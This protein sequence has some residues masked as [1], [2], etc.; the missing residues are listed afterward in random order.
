MHTE[1]CSPAMRR[2][3]ILL[4]LLAGFTAAS[5]AAPAEFPA[6]TG[7][8]VDEAGLLS[9]AARAQL[10]GELAAHEQ[11]TTNQVVVVTLKSLQGY[12]IDDYGYQLGR[13]WGIGQAKLNN[14]VLLIV[15]PA[16]KKVRIEVGYGMEGK[17]T[18]AASHQI[19]QDRIKPQFRQARMEQGI[20]DGTHAILA[21]LAGEA[22]PDA[23]A[24]ATPADSGWWVV[25]VVLAPFLLLPLLFYALV[26]WANRQ[27]VPGVG[28]SASRRRGAGDFVSGS[29]WDSGSSWSGGG[30]S[31]GDSFSG[32][33]GSFGGGGA[34]GDW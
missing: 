18:D 7:R 25:A 26:R 17:L 19:I 10:E 1:A 27:A 32:G 9:P 6:L 21:V 28:R 2:Y 34:S 30:S 12:A 13:H 5:A 15:A 33:G 8:V 31:G 23:P 11:A 29:S 24:P 14:G 3:H 16:E 22:A 20:L 4:L